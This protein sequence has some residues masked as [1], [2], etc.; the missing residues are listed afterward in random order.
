MVWKV[1][2][3][4]NENIHVAAPVSVIET[5]L[6]SYH[7]PVARFERDFIGLEN[8]I[9]DVFSDSSHQKISKIA[10]DEAYKEML[11]L[12]GVRSWRK[13]TEKFKSYSI[14]PVSR[15][16]YVIARSKYF[17]EKNSR[18]FG[19]DEELPDLPIDLSERGSISRSLAQVFAN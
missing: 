10:S 18:G 7:G 11:R 17:S 1:V 19:R 4:H 12:L 5:G 16:E 15:G 6:P 9:R 3:Y 8:F 13:I 14:L 2:V